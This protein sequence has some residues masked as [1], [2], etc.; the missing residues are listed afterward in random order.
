MLAVPASVQTLGQISPTV[1]FHLLAFP[2][3]RGMQ[4]TGQV[5]FIL[6]HN[7]G[8][9]LLRGKLSGCAGCF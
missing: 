9:F 3:C 1:T 7:M 5:C 2:S 4:N 6:K 8:F